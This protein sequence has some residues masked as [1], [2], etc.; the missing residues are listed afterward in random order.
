[1]GGLK[2]SDPASTPLAYTRGLQAN[3]TWNIN[4]GVYKDTGGFIAYLGGNV[5]FVPNTTTLFTSNNSARKVTD[6]RQGIPQ[7]ARIYGTPPAGQAI[8]SNANGVLATR[9]P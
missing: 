7:T 9:G 3:G 8:L 6:I 2:S 1:V 5:N 4:S